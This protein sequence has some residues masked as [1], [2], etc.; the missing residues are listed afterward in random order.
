M[1]MRTLFLILAL[2]LTAGA[3]VAPPV[4]GYLVRPDSRLEWIGGMPGAAQAVA[5]DDGILAVASTT[6]GLVVRT[7]EA[8]EWR[9]R[10]GRSLGMLAAP[11]G[12][13]LLA[14]WQGGPIIAALVADERDGCRLGVFRLG[15]AGPEGRWEN[16]S[17]DPQAVPAG[18]QMVSNSHLRVAWTFRDGASLE[19]VDARTMDR[20]VI[21]WSPGLAGPVALDAAG[22]LVAAPAEFAAESLTPMAGDWFALV[23]QGAS[24]FWRPG[25]LPIAFPRAA[26]DPL[27]LEWRKTLDE[28]VAVADTFPMPP[29][30]SGAPSEVRFRVRNNS[31][32]IVRL[33]RLLAEGRGFSVFNEP[34][35]PSDIAPGA[36][37]EFWIRYQPEGD[38]GTP[39]VLRLNDRRVTLE[40]TVVAI[41]LPEVWS[42]GQWK[43]LSTQQPNRVGDAERGQPFSARLRMLATAGEPDVPSINGRFSLVSAKG[44]EYTLTLDTSVSGMAEGVLRVSGRDYRL[45]VFV[46]EPAPPRFT[47]RM[48]GSAAGYA[49][50]EVIRLALAESSRTSAQGEVSVT[51]LPTVVG[52]KGDATI[53]FLP[54]LRR[55]VPFTVAAGSDQVRFG[56]EDH[57]LLQ[58]GTTAGTLVVRASM[59]GQSEELRLNLAPTP[60]ALQTAAIEAGD[61]RVTMR[62]VGFDPMRDA[63]RAAFTFYLRNG[64]VAAPGRI[65]TDVAA[66][67]RAYFGEEATTSGGFSLSAIFPVSGTV[68]ELGAVELELMNSQ[69]STRSQ[70]IT[71]P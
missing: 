42:S 41:T 50:Q 61:Q 45:Q 1:N 10:E 62:V 23:S 14:A 67:F 46:F 18:L 40:P 9:D 26:E 44:G 2:S 66:T 48:E 49:R 34:P 51:F 16:F 59:A 52:V 39:G 22:R 69:G 60:P 55:S 12:R 25:A 30:A 29:A 57:L 35:I 36:A 63:A 31:N 64:Q 68:S 19:E 65:E 53:G 56:E 54:S 17:C 13:T 47:L 7:R 8:L 28:S 32:G 5:L 70:R 11:A 21:G 71:L 6:L 58:T 24:Y 20:Q 27:E 3:Q 43:A 37:K 15:S 38:G 33:F 4:A